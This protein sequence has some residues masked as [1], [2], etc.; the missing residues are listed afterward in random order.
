M[1]VTLIATS[2]ILIPKARHV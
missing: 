1:H 2:I